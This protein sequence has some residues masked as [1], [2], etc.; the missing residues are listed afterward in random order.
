MLRRV[1]SLSW[2]WAG[3]GSGGQTRTALR[4]S[5]TAGEQGVGEWIA[6]VSLCARG[7]ST[8]RRPTAVGPPGKGLAPTYMIL[9]TIRLVGE[10]NQTA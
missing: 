7:A 4:R 10:D 9:L 5:L 2:S 8:V 6:G 1:A 3:G